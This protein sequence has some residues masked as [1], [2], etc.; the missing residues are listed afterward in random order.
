MRTS[1]TV[2]ALLGGALLACAGAVAAQ[3]AKA[4]DGYLVG[5]NG[6]T[7][8]TFDRDAPN[9]GKSACSGPC[10]TVWPPLMATNSDKPSGAWSIV[11]R[12][13]GSRQWAY[14]GRPLHFYQQDTKAGDRQGDGIGG[15]WHAAKE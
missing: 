14:K 9:G 11:A 15:M 2:S 4:A 13:D 8:Y 3:P 6:L 10:A 1:T 5:A 12:D 7:L